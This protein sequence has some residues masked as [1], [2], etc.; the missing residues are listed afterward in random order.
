MTV[1]VNRLNRA[2]K[3]VTGKPTTAHSAERLTSEAKLLLHHTHWSVGN[4]A[5]RFGFEYDT[6]FHRSFKQHTGTTPL[7]FRQAA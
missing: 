4:I 3:E 6:C 7:G 2:V 1:D 5:D